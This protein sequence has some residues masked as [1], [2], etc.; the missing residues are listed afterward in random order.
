MATISSPE[1]TAVTTVAPASFP[2]P[3]TNLTN[4]TATTAAIAHEEARLQSQLRNETDVTYFE[5]GYVRPV[6]ATVLNES[7]DGLYVRVDATYS[8]GT[9]DKSADGVPVVSLYHVNET[10]IR[11]VNE[12]T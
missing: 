2:S 4:E 7:D 3:P 11:H 1:T 10:T 9:P 6:N 8:Y 12:T 5:L